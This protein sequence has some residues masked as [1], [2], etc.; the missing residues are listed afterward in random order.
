MGWK[1]DCGY[2]ADKELEGHMGRITNGDVAEVKSSTRSTAST[3]AHGQVMKPSVNEGKGHE[4]SE[5]IAGSQGLKGAGSSDHRQQ[6]NSLEAVLWT[7]EDTSH[8]DTGCG[9]EKHL[10]LERGTGQSVI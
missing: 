4:L 2:R 3:K 5:G 6:R 1:N 9:R 10:L 8:T 7:Q